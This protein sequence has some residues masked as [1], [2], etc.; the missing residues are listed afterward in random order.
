MKNIKIDYIPRYTYNDY[1]NWEGR[2]EL[3]EGLPYAMTPLPI[4]E[5]Q[6]VSKNIL[7]QLSERLKDCIKCKALLP[8]DWKID[9]DTVLQPDNSVV[10]EEVGGDRKSV[11]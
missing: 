8:V 4:I 9:N 1:L 2:W 7:L 6:E 3:I 10:C 5:H 11:V